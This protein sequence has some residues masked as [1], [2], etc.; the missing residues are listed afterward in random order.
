[1]MSMTQTQKLMLRLTMTLM[2]EI[3]PKLQLTW[4]PKISNTDYVIKLTLILTAS[5]DTNTGT[6][7]DT[8]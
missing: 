3:I 5:A 2:T 4:I 7:T 6:L 8:Y 1:M